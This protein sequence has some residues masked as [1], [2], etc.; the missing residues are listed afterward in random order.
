MTSFS[1]ME[2]DAIIICPKYT[3]IVNSLKFWINLHYI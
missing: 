1:L 2:N 3:K